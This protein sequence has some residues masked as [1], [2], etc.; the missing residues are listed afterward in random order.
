MSF[1][2]FNLIIFAIEAV[3]FYFYI[4]KL[5]CPE[6]GNIFKAITYKEMGISG[7]VLIFAWIGYD[8]YYGKPV[9][10]WGYS[11]LILCDASLFLHKDKF[12]CRHCM[13]G[14]PFSEGDVIR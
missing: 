14:V 4:K 12:Y 9:E 3:F 10:I 8:L 2:K 5:K 1:I 13:K 6:C 11:L 7:L